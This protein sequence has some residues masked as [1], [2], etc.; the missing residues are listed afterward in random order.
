MNLAPVVD[1]S[2]NSR[3]FMYQ[4]ALGQNAE[5]TAEYAKTVIEASKG[6]NVSYT[7]KHFPGY[8]NNA[9]THTGG[10][11]NFWDTKF[12]LELILTT[13]PPSSSAAINNGIFDA[14]WYAAISF[15]TVCSDLFLKSFAKSKYPPKLYFCNSVIASCS[16]K[17]TTKQTGGA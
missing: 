16:G 1:V 8:G 2:T 4:R 12:G 17:R 5:L 6:Y 10:D 9:D 13:V 14:S 7:L 3:D 11:L 15:F